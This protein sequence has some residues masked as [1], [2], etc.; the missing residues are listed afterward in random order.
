MKDVGLSFFEVS[1][2]AFSPS[3]SLITMI[4]VIARSYFII[5]TQVTRLIRFIRFIS[6]IWARNKFAEVL[7]S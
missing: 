6:I 7:K 1:E 4:N 2:M 5:I 3:K